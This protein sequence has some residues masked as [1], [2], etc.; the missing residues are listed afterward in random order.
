MHHD[1]QA[2]PASPGADLAEQHDSFQPWSEPVTVVVTQAFGPEGHNLVGYSDVT[3]NGH[4]AITVLVRTPEGREGLVHLSP[5]YGDRRKQG[6]T[7]IAPGTRCTLCCPAT[8]K[9]LEKLGPVDDGS[10]A[11]YYA[12]YLTS[13]LI[14]GHAVALS[15]V[16]DHHHSRIVDDDAVISYWAQ[17]HPI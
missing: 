7:D 2:T 16:W 5:I 17:T 14:K 3:F 13:R 10:G 11:D 15:D 12:L 1:I 6:F 8:G 4:P 9:P